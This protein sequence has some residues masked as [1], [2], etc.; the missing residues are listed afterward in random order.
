MG[1]DLKAFQSD[2]RALRDE[3]RWRLA[4]AEREVLLEW[5]AL[6]ARLDEADRNDVPALKLEVSAFKQR[7]AVR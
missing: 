6:E 3:M 7:L 5:A 1:A 2:V 4:L